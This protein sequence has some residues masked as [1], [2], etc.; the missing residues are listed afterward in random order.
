LKKKKFTPLV[1]LI[2]DAIDD[3]KGENITILDLRNLENSVCDFFVI[4]E[5]NSNTQVNAIANSI[6]KKVRENL[7][8]KPWHIE[9]L[10]NSEW[11]LMDY[12]SVAIHI[13]QKHIRE[14]Y[15]L[16]GLWG[17]AEVS[18]VA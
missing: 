14:F 7:S 13:F 2:I 8:E 1:D 11:I 4:C 18:K 10:E 16:E 15:D 9:G 5:A 3:I 6:E 17:D 12:V